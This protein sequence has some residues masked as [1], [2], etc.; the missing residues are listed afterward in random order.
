MLD[1]T[2]SPSQIARRCSCAA[3][4]RRRAF[5]PSRRPAPRG[6]PGRCVR[7]PFRC[8]WCGA[9]PRRSGCGWWR[10]RSSVSS[11]TCSP[12]TPSCSARCCPRPRLAPTGTSLPS[13]PSRTSSSPTTSRSGHATQPRHV[14]KRLV[15][16]AG[17]AE[18]PCAQV[19]KVYVSVFG[20]ERGRRWPLK[21][22]RPRPSTSGAK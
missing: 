11:P 8:A 21:G 9:W 20:D 17:D 13:P 14:P 19:C 3:L 22:S 2:L 6:P 10:S 7:P 18:F 15:S 1:T 4:W 12:A 16:C 5:S